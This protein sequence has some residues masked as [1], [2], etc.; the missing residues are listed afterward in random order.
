MKE[1]GKDEKHVLTRVGFGIVCIMKFRRDWR[2]GRMLSNNGALRTTLINNTN[3][4][5]SNRK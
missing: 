4:G 3:Q 1:E 2:C 5:K